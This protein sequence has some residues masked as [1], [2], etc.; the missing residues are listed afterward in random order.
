METVSQR[1]SVLR[2]YL[3]MGGVACPCLTQV[4]VQNRYLHIHWLHHHALAN[5]G[6]KPGHSLSQWGWGCRCE[7][8]RQIWLSPLFR[9]NEWIEPIKTQILRIRHLNDHNWTNLYEMFPHCRNLV[10]ILT[11]SFYREPAM[12][13]LLCWWEKSL[14]HQHRDLSPPLKFWTGRV[15]SPP[16]VP[17]WGFIGSLSGF[18]LT[19]RSKSENFKQASTA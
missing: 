15:R 4:H 8:G 16:K 6:N 17:H 9:V 18:I 5:S 10:S 3:W 2:L 7:I 19:F 12:S 1:E 11:A 13:L 14:P